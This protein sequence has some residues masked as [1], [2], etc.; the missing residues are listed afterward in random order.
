[1][2]SEYKIKKNEMSWEEKLEKRYCTMSYSFLVARTPHSQYTFRSIASTTTGIVV[3]YAI[4]RELDKD[5][6]RKRRIVSVCDAPHDI[7]GSTQEVWEKARKMCGFVTG[8]LRV[9]ESFKEM[10]LQDFR[11]SQDDSILEA[12]LRPW[13]FLRCG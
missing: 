7:S 6:G 12:Q 9:G 11:V 5:M 13:H 4:C 2:N 10:P 8:D 1:M 3:A